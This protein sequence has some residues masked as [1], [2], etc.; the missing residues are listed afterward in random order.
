MIRK[1]KFLKKTLLQP[2]S[3]SFL[4]PTNTLFLEQT[5]AQWQKEPLSVPLSFRLYFEDM[6]QEEYFPLPDDV[7]DIN[8]IPTEA[9]EMDQSKFLSEI[10]KMVSNFE[11]HGHFFSDVDPTHINIGKSQKI[12]ARFKFNEL[13]SLNIPLQF[14]DVPL[15]KDFPYTDKETRTPRQLHQKLMKLYAGPISFQYTN[16]LDEE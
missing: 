3:N 8:F 5:Y 2:T 9:L 14:Y 10:H 6:D 1:L 7:K 15:P 11:Q 16:M 12:H 4:N 13:E